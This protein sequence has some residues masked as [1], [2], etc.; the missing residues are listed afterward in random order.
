MSKQTVMNFEA[1]QF[2]DTPVA[3]FQTITPEI[4]KIMLG[5]NSQNRKLNDRLKAELVRSIQDGSLAM[6]GETIKFSRP[7]DFQDGRP[8]RPILLD[9]QHR[10][11]AIVQSGIAVEILVVRGLEPETQATM[12]TG[13]KRTGADW[14]RI[15][16]ESEY[17]NL[18]AMISGI[19]K[20][21]RSDRM[22]LTSPKPTPLEQSALLEEYPQIRRSLKIG[23]ETY[24]EFPDI[25]KTSYAIG[26]FIISEIDPV[27][28]PYLFRLAGTGAGLVVG[29]PV[30]A[31]TKRA[32][33][34]RRTGEPMT[35][36]REV[37][38]IIQAWNKCVS[39]TTIKS[40]SQAIDATVPEPSDPMGMHIPMLADAQLEPK[41]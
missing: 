31:M 7:V 32:S 13:R 4:A 17:N 40:M 30:L 34:Y 9:G 26:H 22:F 28:A 35:V 19:W 27:H 24:R 6:N 1:L 10:L 11:E 15:Q 33:S 14:F 8:P 23:I 41:P 12:D 39:N 18:A 37:G 29:H 25:R 20:W 2:P 5:F 16:G 21:Q 36:R 38:L 3:G